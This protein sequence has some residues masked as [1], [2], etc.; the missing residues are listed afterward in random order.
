MNVACYRLVEFFAWPT[1][2]RWVLRVCRQV[3]KGKG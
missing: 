3:A 1:A 2:A